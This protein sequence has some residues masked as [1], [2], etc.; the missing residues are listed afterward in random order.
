M[1]VGNIN[2]RIGC[3]V[4]IQ[5]REKIEGFNGCVEENLFCVF[6]YNDVSFDCLVTL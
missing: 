2:E 3:W 5:D 4:K 1:A 6:R